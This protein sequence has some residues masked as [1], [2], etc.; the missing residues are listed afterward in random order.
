MATIQEFLVSIGYD[1]RERDVSAWE[2]LDKK[3]DVW[4]AKL[5]AALDGFERRAKDLFASATNDLDHLNF[6]A[7]RTG[8]SV[9]SL[10]AMA[11]AMRQLGM[12]GGRAED[13]VESF[14]AHLRKFP[15]LTGILRG[16]GVRT[17]AGSSARDTGEVFRDTISAL[18]GIKNYSV[19][20]H[21]AEI[22]GIAEDDYAI[23]RKQSADFEKFQREQME[24]YKRYGVDASEGGA[25]SSA[26]KIAWR[27]M[28]LSAD[29]MLSKI[30][31]SIGAMV[32]P[33]LDDL[34]LWIDRHQSAIVAVAAA[35]LAAVTDLG[36]AL[37]NMVGAVFGSGDK[38]LEFVEWAAGSQGVLRALEF[39]TAT[40]FA[41]ILAGFAGPVGLVAAG[42]LALAAAVM[43]SKANAEVPSD[44][45]PANAAGA[46]HGAT[47]SWGDPAKSRGAT[48][49]WG[50]WLGGRSRA[51]GGAGAAGAGGGKWEGPVPAPASEPDQALADDRRKFAE[52]MK[53][54]AVAAR[55]AA[56]VESEVGSQGP[57]AQQAFVESIMNRA[58]SRGQTLRQ[59]LDGPYF[60]GTTHARARSLARD[61]RIADKYGPMFGAAMGGS[62]ISGFATGNGS[63]GVKFGGG[64]QTSSYGGEDYG[65]EKADIGWARR[66]QELSRARRTPP[67][68]LPPKMEMP[69]F[70]PNSMFEAPPLGAAPETSLSADQVTEIRVFGDPDPVRTSGEVGAIQHRVNSDFVGQASK[71]A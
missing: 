37:Q 61:P 23:L 12:D 33:L 43:P 60:P 29:A 39:M 44:N 63:L 21:Y 48:G 57:K 14:A 26:L 53:D 41:G 70:D 36:A 6:A 67:P 7:Q 11:Y 2:A 55:F 5:G 64:P 66:M 62:N 3:V 68:A 8:A 51:M 20:T 42:I 17:G 54:P 15:S 35:L 50:S 38:F 31:L 9:D 40:W 45:A 56:F 19:A 47:G 28:L 10:K 46:T 27:Q 59:T 30:A 4:L 34:K 25:Q 49:S 52:E 18:N 22:F 71:V 58:S 13:L 16:M 24:V 1:V 69:G 65:I 32:V